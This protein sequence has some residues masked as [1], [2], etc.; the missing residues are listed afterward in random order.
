MKRFQLLVIGI[1][2]LLLFGSVILL[3]HDQVKEKVPHVNIVLP[4]IIIVLL[5][6]VKLT[7]F[8]L[9]KKEN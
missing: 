1:F 2:A 6:L 5:I 9:R 7:L 3:T 8:F 4:T